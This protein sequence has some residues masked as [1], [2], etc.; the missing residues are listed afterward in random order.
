MAAGD[1]VHYICALSHPESAAPKNTFLEPNPDRF[2]NH[3]TRSTFALPSQPEGGSPGRFLASFRKL[4]EM[5]SIIPLNLEMLHSHRQRKRFDFR[6]GINGF[7]PPFRCPNRSKR[8]RAG[9]KSGSHVGVAL[10][11]HHRSSSQRSPRDAPSRTTGKW[12]TTYSSSK[13][14]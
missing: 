7:A 5:V 3:F 1:V 10:K 12:K 11:P 8:H 4:L 9:R 13:S 2:A 6:P 14:Y